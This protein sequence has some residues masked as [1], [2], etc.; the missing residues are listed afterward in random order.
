VVRLGYEL[1]HLDL[2]LWHEIQAILP[3]VEIG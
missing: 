1:A 3:N 2:L